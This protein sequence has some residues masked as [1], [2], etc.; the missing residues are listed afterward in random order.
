MKGLI[1]LLLFAIMAT[2]CSSPNESHPNKTQQSNDWTEVVQYAKENLPLE[3][4]LMS[5]SH[6]YVYLKVDD[7]YI[8]QLFPMLNIKNEGYKEPPFFRRKSSPGAHIS[9]FYSNEHIHPKELGKKFSFELKKVAIVKQKGSKYVVLQVESP[10]LEKL[11]EKYGLGPKLYGHEYHI[12]IGK[13][14]KHS[15]KQF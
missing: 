7:G 12:S 14:S 15:K 3:G 8:H 1:S 2:S 10:E 13:K 5:N 6:G 11:R 9:V 4:S